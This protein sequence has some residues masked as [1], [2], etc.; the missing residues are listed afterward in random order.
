MQH[1]TKKVN[2]F[3]R[4][5]GMCPAES[6]YSDMLN[7]WMVDTGGRISDTE[8]LQYYISLI[9]MALKRGRIRA[10]AA[11]RQTPEK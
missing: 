2:S 3:I 11:A 7:G 8:E 9:P 6:P 1:D 10:A 5:V 4:Y